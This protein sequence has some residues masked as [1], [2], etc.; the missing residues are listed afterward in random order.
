METTF[1]WLKLEIN[2]IQLS[3]YVVSH[4]VSELKDEDINNLVAIFR[5]RDKRYFKDLDE[6]KF[7]LLEKVIDRIFFNELINPNGGN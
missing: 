3:N 4:N 1:K 2:G 7:Q 5:V 6:T